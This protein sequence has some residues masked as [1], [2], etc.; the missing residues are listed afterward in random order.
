[1]NHQL[2]KSSGNSYKEKNKLK[3]QIYFYNWISKFLMM[4][5]NHI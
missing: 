5:N 2:R 4:I 1:M 3:L